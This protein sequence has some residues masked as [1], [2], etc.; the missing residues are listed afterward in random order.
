[1]DG[2]SAGLQ[3]ADSLAE[4]PKAAR[5]TCGPPPRDFN[6]VARPRSIETRLTDGSSAQPPAPGGRAR[7]ARSRR[8]PGRPWYPPLI[9]A[10]G[11]TYAPEVLPGVAEAVDAERSGAGA[12]AG[13]SSRGRTATRRGRARRVP[14][15]LSDRAELSSHVRRYQSRRST[16]GEATRQ[17]S[18]AS[19]AKDVAYN[20]GLTRDGNADGCQPRSRQQS[21]YTAARRSR[22]RL[23]L[24]VRGRSWSSSCSCPT[25][26]SAPGSRQCGWPSR[27]RFPPSGSL[28]ALEILS[29]DRS[30]FVLDVVRALFTS[31]LVEGDVRQR[32]NLRAALLAAP[33]TPGE[34]V[35]LPLDASIWRETL[36][37]RQV[38]DNQIIGAILSDRST[39]LLYH[40]LAGLDDETLAWL[41]PERETLRH[42]LRHAGAFAVFGRACACGPDASSSPAARTPSRCGR[43]SSAPIRPGRRPSCDGSSATSRA[44]WRGST[45]RWRTSTSRGCDLPRARRCRRRRAS[46]ACARCSTSSSASATSG[47]RRSSRSAAGRSTRR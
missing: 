21:V 20:R 27:C 30:R 14:T 23:E 7:A 3:P 44:C 19:A 17:D 10:P 31:G 5:L 8:H 16:K 2:P 36:L 1:M 42:L 34:T 13:G 9:Y 40:G 47:S 11:F 38:P 28:N 15:E 4:R 12:R 26:Q 37:Q 24:C 46:S 35:P 39:A 18:V 41:G 25:G 45:T 22:H 43:R 32:E 29:I 33:S 6:R